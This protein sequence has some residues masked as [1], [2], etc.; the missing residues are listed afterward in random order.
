MSNDFIVVV[1]D[2]KG[3]V[4]VSKVFHRERYDSDDT[5]ERAIARHIGCLEKKYSEDDYTI[6]QG[7]ASNVSSF[8]TAYPEL[9]RKF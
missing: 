5:Y 2:R 9:A 3:A 7:S 6:H 1:T 4:V 8:F